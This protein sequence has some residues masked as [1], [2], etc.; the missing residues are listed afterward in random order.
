MRC[1]G[2]RRSCLFGGGAAALAIVVLGLPAAAQAQDSAARSRDAWHRTAQ[3]APAPGHQVA[4]A[5]TNATYFDLDREPLAAEARQAPPAGAGSPVVLSIPEPDGSFARYEVTR[6]TTLSPE[7]AAKHPGIRDFVGVGVDDPTASLS[8]VISPQGAFA[9]VR[10]R[11]GTSYV[12]P[13]Y[14]DDATAHVAFAREDLPNTEPLRESEEMA[15]QLESAAPRS[16]A[17]PGPGEDVPLRTYRLALINDQTYANFFGGSDAEVLA[18]K[19]ALMARVNQIYRQDLGITMTLIPQTDALNLN[20]DAEAINPGGPCGGAACYTSAQL[21]RCTDSTLTQTTIVA[22]QIAGARNYDI[23]HLALGDGGGGLAAAGV[24]DFNKAEGCTGGNGSPTGDAFGVDFVAHEMGHQFSADHTWNGTRRDCTDANRVDASAMEPGSGSTIMGYAGICD[25]DNLQPHSDPYFSQRSQEQMYGWVDA[26]A[27]GRET[28]PLSSVQ[29]VSLR[30]FD[31]TD[32]F[33][34]SYGGGAPQTITN[35]TNYT[36]DGIKDAIEAAIGGGTTVTV[37]NWQGEDAGALDENGF[38]VTFDSTV[39]E[40]QLALSNFSGASGFVGDAVVG[41]PRNNG[42]A[43]TTTSNK[44]PGVQTAP[45]FTI[46]VRTPFTLTATGSD[47]NPAD[48]LTYLWEQ[49]DPGTGLALGTEPG[50]IGPLFRVFGVA[51]RTDTGAVYNSTPKNATTT[52]PARDFPDVAQVMADNTDAVNECGPVTTD[53]GND[54]WSE[55][56]PKVN[57]TMTFRVT[58]RDGNPEAGGTGFADTALTVSAAAGPF[59]LTSQATDTNNGS[60]ARLPVTW[61]VAGTDAAPIS[62]SS[63]RILLSTDDGASFPT[64]L[65]ASTPNDG[66]ESVRLPAGVQ[67]TTGRIRIEAVGNVFYDASRGRLSFNRSQGPS[68]AASP[69]SASFGSVTVG[70]LSNPTSVSVTNN[71][72]GGADLGTVAISG[73]DAGQFAIV[74][75]GCSGGALA[76]GG[77]SCPVSVR[78]APTSAGSKSATLT[79]PDLEGASTN[80]SLTGTG[81]GATTRVTPPPPTAARVRLTAARPQNF[82][83]ARAVVVK[84]MVDRDAALSATGSIAL[85]KGRAAPR[86]RLRAATGRAVAG[87][88]TTLKLK[89]NSR[90]LRR[91]RAAVRAKRRATASVS[92]RVAPANAP[93]TVVRTSIRHK[94]AAKPTRPMTRRLIFDVPSPI[95]S[96]G[97]GLR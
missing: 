6:G 50:T 14:R 65:A 97:T 2:G 47:A 96:W 16:A 26:P 66:S 58:A 85:G 32:S 18:A 25:L 37:T 75:D 74:A 62:T 68:L 57:R 24:G 11:N 3:R 19:T 17:R 12:E 91:L 48:T 39:D 59:R 49:S 53:A 43:V 35:G 29:R 79:V 51:Q 77:G 84:V 9:A 87:R 30:D 55:Y 41:G 20:T 83:R 5:P 82:L 64:V 22:G 33:D 60:A 7:L 36:L 70:Q 10:G 80:V 93:A 44:A 54:C 72:G 28:P 69:S 63:V 27:V 42:G 89:L 61:S 15:R 21:A 1:A 81:V 40:P 71:G 73:P 95:S 56:L 88:T 92:V 8:L 38:T 67:T 46:P 13:R 31:G 90:A 52:N 78:F 86:L 94:G 23:G 4:V 76:A 34:I 45:G